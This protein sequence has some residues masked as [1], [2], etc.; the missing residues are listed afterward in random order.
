MKLYNVRVE[1]ELVVLAESKEEA[2]KVAS[3]VWKDEEPEY[4]SAQEMSFYPGS[5]D[6]KCLPFISSKAEE[7]YED[8]TIG[9]CIKNG[10][11][12]KMRVKK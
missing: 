9:D 7:E 5:W 3:R 6:E 11:A 12:P 4:Y 8:L 10:F 2:D 1:V